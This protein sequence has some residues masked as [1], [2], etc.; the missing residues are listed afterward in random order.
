[1]KAARLTSRLLEVGLI[2]VSPESDTQRSFEYYYHKN[3]FESRKS[4]CYSDIFQVRYNRRVARIFKRG[5]HTIS[6]PGYLLDCH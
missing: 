1:M 4:H 5:V 3:H 2:W 6:H